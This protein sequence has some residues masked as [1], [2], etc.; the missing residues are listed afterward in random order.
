MS[1][2][3]CLGVFAG[4]MALRSWIAARGRA[5]LAAAG[6]AVVV[7]C[8][9]VVPAVASAAVCYRP[10]STLPFS[11][12]ASPAG[13]AVDRS[14]DVFLADTADSRILELSPGADGNCLTG[15]RRRCRSAVICPQ[16]VAVDGSGD[17]FVGDSSTTSASSRSCHRART[18]L[19]DGTQSTLPVAGLTD[20]M[21]WRS[22]RPGTCSSRIRE[23][24]DG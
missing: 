1:L 14:G 16:E 24:H 18:G 21:G 3:C 22:T 20:P 10:Q 6:V 11:G 7:G 15:R 4:L 2:V 19:S 13:V 9:G 8:L 12:L 17:V 23:H 5:H